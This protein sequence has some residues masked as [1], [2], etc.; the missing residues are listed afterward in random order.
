MHGHSFKIILRLIGPQDPEIGWV[1][2]YHEIDLKMKPLLK[3]IDHRVLN[4][5]AGLENPTSE[6]LAAWIFKNLQKEVPELIQVIV[7][8]TPDTECRFPVI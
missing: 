4:E 6:N 5:V 1:R 3:Q 8:E 2:D 7:K